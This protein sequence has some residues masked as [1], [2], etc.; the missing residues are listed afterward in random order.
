MSIVIPQHVGK[1]AQLL[2]DALPQ[3]LINAV[4]AYLYDMVR[5]DWVQYLKSSGF[6]LSHATRYRN[7]DDVYHPAFVEELSRY[8]PH[9]CQYLCTELF[10]FNVD[11][12]YF[13]VCRTFRSFLI[14]D[15][16]TLVLFPKTEHGFF[17]RSNDIKEWVSPTDTYRDTT[18]CN[19]FVI[20]SDIPPFL[21]NYIID[22]PLYIRKVGKEKWSENFKK[23]A[24]IIKKECN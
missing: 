20:D 13:S 21:I 11:K 15:R 4:S 19:I 18:G 3:E 10:Q 24:C 2:E 12:K 1:L 5:C 16:V 23:L 8:Y 7:G 9:D 17:V 6:V 22:F 14:N